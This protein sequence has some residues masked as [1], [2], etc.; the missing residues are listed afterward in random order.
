MGRDVGEALAHI[1]DRGVGDGDSEGALEAVLAVHRDAR[2]EAIVDDHGHGRMGIE[3]ALLDAVVGPGLRD[4][5]L[6]DGQ[7]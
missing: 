6:E 7:T 4:R 2:E 5:G 3:G 1:S